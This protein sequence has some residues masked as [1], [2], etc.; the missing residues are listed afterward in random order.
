MISSTQRAQG[1]LAA[2]G[3]D[4]TRLAPYIDGHF[5]RDYTGDYCAVVD[6]AT[7]EPLIE[8]AD[9]QPADID[10][11]VASARAS[12]ESGAWARRRPSQRGQ[13][14]NRI[15]LTLR[16]RAEH[17]AVIETLDVGKPHAEALAD[18]EATARYFEFYAG[19]ADKHGGRTVP[20]ADHLVDFTLLEPIGVS[21]QIIPFNYPAQNTGRG[22]APALAMG[23]SVVLKPSPDCP[24]NPLLIAAIATECGVP[25]GVFNVVPGGVD[26]GRTLS[27]H[28]G[29][30]QIT[31]TG[32]VATGKEVALAAARN[33]TPSVLELGGKSPVVVFD[34]ADFELAI[35]GVS[36]SIFSNAGQTC[37]AGTRLL[38]QRSARGE[39]FLDLLVERARSLTIGEGIEG[40]TL[41]P[42]V[43]KRQQERVAAYLEAACEGGGV[44]LTGGG[45]P[46]RKGYFV[47]P[48]V[49]EVPNNKHRLAQ[50][51]IFGP[52][53]TVIRFDGL[54]EAAEIANDSEFGLSSYV[55]TKDI[56][57]ALSLAKRIRAGQVNI[58]TFE[59][60]TGIEIPFGGFKNSGWG[61]EKGIE[62]LASYT[63]TKNVCIGLNTALTR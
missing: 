4:S 1:A 60:G 26:A 44:V 30:D 37:A 12:F 15:A 58:N 31:F 16:E 32:S 39:E 62:T 36:G 61:R 33:V 25:A 19:L 45:V 57:K 5:Q 59:V 18:I 54:E 21:G 55:W 52:V 56:D 11:A 27:S 28:P 23:C 17:L 47:E 20:L 6:P 7:E 51:E 42:L 46:D 41:G 53:M 43:S 50:E 9:G 35:A 3:I 2:L 8:V 63:Q 10:R 14:L 22:G 13:I 34:D 29:I 49:V 24:L 40:A 48:T 38:V